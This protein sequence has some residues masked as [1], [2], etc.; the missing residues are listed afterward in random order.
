VKKD[1]RISI[2]PEVKM[3]K[4]CIRG[5][6]ITVKS[7]IER[8]DAGETKEQILKVHPRLTFEDI[9]AAIKYYD[10]NMRIL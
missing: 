3:G 7:I 9:N 2:N 6:G 8:I 5:T 4:P 10:I 1:F